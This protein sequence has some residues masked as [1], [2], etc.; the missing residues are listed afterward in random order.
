MPPSAARI[1]IFVRSTAD[2][3]S[4]GLLDAL[5]LSLALQG[6]SSLWMYT[7]V[8]QM[9]NITYIEVIHYAVILIRG[10]YYY[11]QEFNNARDTAV[12]Q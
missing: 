7:A 5:A 10:A 2:L 4:G 9:Q 6:L 3:T 1:D 11:R 8:H 12:Q